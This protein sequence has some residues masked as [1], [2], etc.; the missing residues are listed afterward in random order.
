[1]MDRLLHS[2]II[3][4]TI[5][6]FG[7]TA[8]AAS[9]REA[10]QH[11]RR[12]EVHFEEARFPEALEEYA[13]AFDAAPLPAFLFNIGQCHVELEQYEAAISH[14]ERFIA[15]DPPAEQ[16]DLAR[17]QLA[18]A[19][20]EMQ[21]QHNEQLERARHELLVQRER[22][23]NAILKSEAAR[24]ASLER[25]ILDM[26]AEAPVFARP[27]VLA[28]LTTTAALIGG[29]LVWALTAEREARTVLPSGNLGI[30]DGR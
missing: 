8:A 27:W 6:S 23:H 22:E 5:C 4:L 28:T 20:S 24:R 1:M 25:Q 12:A 15:A 19:R 29:G 14:F 3:V 30:I 16:Q 10:R 17:E 13:A 9:K 18:F 2:V 7:A 21:R 26:R 11:F